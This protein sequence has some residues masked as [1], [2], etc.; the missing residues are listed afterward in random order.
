[1]NK[2][3]IPFTVAFPK[4]VFAG[5]LLALTGLSSLHAQTP[6]TNANFNTARDLWFSDQSSATATYGHIKDWNVTGVT[7]MQDAFKDRI[8]FNEDI[9]GWDVSNATN[10]H[11]YVQRSQC[12]QP[13]DR[14]LECFGCQK[15][16][17]YV[18]GSLFF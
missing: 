9:S 1:M 13:T 8:N 7:N 18:Y 16:A 12:I 6:L 11:R 2:Y 15:Y 3:D 17:L 5:V 10:M 14:R 4:A